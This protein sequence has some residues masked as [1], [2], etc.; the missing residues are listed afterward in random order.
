MKRI[1]LVIQGMITIFS[2]LFLSQECVAGVAIEQ[3][4]KDMEGRAST[5][6]LYFSEN[7]FRTDH[8]EGGLATII[9]FKNDRMVMIDH[10]SKSYAETKLSQW[11]REIANRL[12]EEAPAIKPKARKIVVKKTGETATINGFRT[13][14]IQILAEGE[15]IEEN[16]VTRDVAMEEIGEVMDRIAQGFS[17]EF[18]SEMREGQEIYE[19]LKPYGFPI[20]IKD[21]TIA[22]G[23]GMDVLEVKKLEKKELKEEVF[24]P[25][26]GYH[27]MVPELPQK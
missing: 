6:F 17:K 12:K 1:A 15:L 2:L 25:P 3:M 24:L 21:Y 11:Q 9:D 18:R 13:E 19:K 5:V 7:Q 22:Y 14:K 10:R 23:L 8:P 20:L 16:W 27:R 4:V 26:N